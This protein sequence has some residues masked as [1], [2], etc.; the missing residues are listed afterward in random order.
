MSGGRPRIHAGLATYARGGGMSIHRTPH[1]TA[2]GAG[3]CAC[4]RSR[5]EVRFDRRR[6]RSLRHRP[7]DLPPGADRRR[8]SARRRRRDRNRARCAAI[9]ARRSWPRRRHE[10]RRTMLQHRGGGR[11]LEIHESHSFA[12]PRPERGLGRA[13]RDERRFARCRRAAPSDLRAP[14]P[15][16]INHSTL[17]GMIGNNSCGVHSVMARQDRRQHRVARRSHL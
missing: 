10:P 4:A 16:R 12:R 11:L 7:L 13:R 15:R 8:H 9:T 1:A 3:A 17:G 14:I 6:P 5:R 2:R